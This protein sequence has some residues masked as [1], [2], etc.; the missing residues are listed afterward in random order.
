MARLEALLQISGAFFMLAYLTR[1]RYNHISKI[2]GVSPLAHIIMV[3][4]CFPQL[5]IDRG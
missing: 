3:C 4:A 5:G 1:I 2:L